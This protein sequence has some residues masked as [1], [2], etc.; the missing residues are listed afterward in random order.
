M[1]K[2]IVKANKYNIKID[3]ILPIDFSNYRE[4]Y[5]SENQIKEEINKLCSNKK[6]VVETNEIKKE[7]VCLIDTNKTDNRGIV[8][9]EENLNYQKCNL[10]VS[11]RNDSSLFCEYPWTTMI[12]NYGGE[13]TFDCSC[14]F[15][16]KLD[17]IN[18]KA[19]LSVWNSE[20]IQIFREKIKK[21]NYYDICSYNCINYNVHK[22]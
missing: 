19:L 6:Y 11:S 12:I 15:F 2:A 17:N 5:F 1:N 7:D 18:D 20:K 14:R 8:V 16:N 13:I 9:E 21:R 10:N 3:N 4:K 22:K